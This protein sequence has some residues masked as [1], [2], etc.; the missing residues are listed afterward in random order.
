MVLPVLE[1]KNPWKNLR[2]NNKTRLEMDQSKRERAKKF[3]KKF[4]IVMNT[5]KTYVLKKL[6]ERFSNSRK[7]GLIDRKLHS[8]DPASI[9][10]GRFKPNF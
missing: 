9:E 5:W 1:D 7:L 2:E 4:E 10:S 6:S 3:L 8:I